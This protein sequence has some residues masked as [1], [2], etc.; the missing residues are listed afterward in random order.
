MTTTTQ[1]HARAPLSRTA[2]P[3][4]AIYAQ[5]IFGP[6]PLRSRVRRALARFAM[7]DCLV[8]AYLTV[9][10]A[11]V[12]LGGGPRR[13]T[14][15]AYVL[16]DA[17]VFFACM[18]IARSQ[19]KSWRLAADILYR[20]GLIG[21]VLGSFLQLQ[22]ILPTASERIVD[23]AI[24][25]VDLAV[26][27]FEPAVAFDHLVTPALTEWFAFFYYSYFFILCAYLFPM[28][29][30]ER[31]IRIL[32]ELSVGLL[33]VVCVGHCLYLVV[34]GRGPY[35]YLAPHFQNQLSGGFWW[36]LVRDAVASVDGASR[37]DIFPSLHTAC[38]TFLTLF[39][40]RNRAHRPYRYIWPVTAFFTSQI[41]LAT[42][43]LRWHY[44]L[45]V[46]AGVTLAVVAFEVSQLIVPAEVRAR[47]E[48]GVGPVWRPLFGGARP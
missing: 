5:E 40:F 13:S 38:P 30:F 31:R 15:I 10:L 45:D 16:A 39:S 28:G 26:F 25:R 17:A 48:L 4:H 36:P 3:H 42:M 14:A 37:T 8:G 2:R 24:Y 23:A 1:R 22:H 19:R 47:K 32:T 18:V 11:C 43:Y 6:A 21:A 35:A 20:V 29:A 46:V 33:L 34:P 9:L 41:I 27:G 7:Q 44:L 12:I